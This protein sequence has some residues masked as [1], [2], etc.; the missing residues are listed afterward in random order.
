[1]PP[2]SAADAFLVLD[3]LAGDRLLPHPVFAALLASLPSL[4]HRTSPRLRKGLALRALDAALSDAADASTLL[5]SCF[6]DCRD[7]AAAVSHLKSLLDVQW[8]HLPPSTLEIAADRIAGAGALQRWA[9]ADSNKRQKLRLLG[10]RRLSFLLSH[11]YC[12]CCC[13]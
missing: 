5:S 6:P 7:D 9:N 11:C 2:L 3:F 8:P 4:S 1:M 12:Y 10:Q 13:P